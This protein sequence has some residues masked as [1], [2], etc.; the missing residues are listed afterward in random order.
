MVALD[1][2]FG[3]VWMNFDMFP[4][5]VFVSQWTD[6]GLAAPDTVTETTGSSSEFAAAASHSRR[7]VARCQSRPG[8]S[9]WGVRV[10]Y[11]DTV[12]VWHELSEPP[13]IDEIHVAMA[14]LSETSVMVVYAGESGLSWARLEGEEWVETGRL[15]TQ[16]WSAI[17]PRLRLRPSGGLWLLTTEGLVAQV[18]AYRDGEWAEVDTLTADHAPGEIFSPAWCSMSQDTAERPLL[19]WSDFG[20]NVPPDVAAVA[21]PTED[22]W[23]QGDVVPNSEGTWDPD[24]A[25]DRNGDAWVA[26]WRIGTNGLY[27][28]HTYVSAISHPPRFDSSRKTP[29]LRWQLAEPAPESWWAVQRAEGSGEFQTLG[30]AQAGEDVYM[31]WN[32]GA[33]PTGTL[34]RYRIRRESLDRRYEW[35]SEEVVWWPRGATLGLRLRGPLPT[36]QTGVELAV[37]GAEGGALEVH[38]Y[39]LQG[40]L[41]LRQRESTSGSGRDQFSLDFGAAQSRMGSGVYFARAADATGRVSQAVK[42]V[43]LR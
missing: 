19:V 33:A 24:V 20:Q 28:N 2:R 6:H 29:S 10:L 7:W 9:L 40:R 32:D 8:S 18:H 25:R 22:G 4:T 23:L 39:D 16:P 17:H 5:R 1:G 35:H 38:V 3:Q 13:G 37:T 14:P 11:S 12:G 21:F 15:R 41:V 34:L 36:F 27:F 31:S 26:W 42:L 30:R 43:V